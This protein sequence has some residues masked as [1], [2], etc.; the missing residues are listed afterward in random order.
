M[1]KVDSVRC[2]IK[3]LELSLLA[4]GKE[5]PS[6]REDVPVD[7]L[8]PKDYVS[9]QIENNFSYHTPKK[10]QPAKYQAIRD[11]AKELAHMIDELCPNSREKSVAQTNLE[12]AVMW[13]N[14]SIA[15][16]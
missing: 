2:Y 3:E 7:Y 15:R 13:A 5:L 1:K 16:N 8:V 9:P 10:G 11:K 14:A 6:N 12:Q 4:S